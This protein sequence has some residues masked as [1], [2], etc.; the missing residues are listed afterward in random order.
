MNLPNVLSFF[1]LCLVPVFVLVYFS[2]AAHAGVYA[3]IVYGIA[4]LSD[5]LD[6]KIA[7]KYHMTSTLGKILDPLGDKLMTFA[8]LIC[9]TIDRVVPLWAILIFVAKESL[10]GI[11]GLILFKRLSD[12]PPSNYFG[13]CP[14]I[15]FFAVCV[16]LIL[17]KRNIS[18]LGA[19]IM[20]SVAI[21][22]TLVAFV[23]Y[24][25]KFARMISGGKTK[26]E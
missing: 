20:I 25:L 6:G 16:I 21:A 13:K 19:T 2:G 5:V 4:A 23:S 22:V 1:R 10:M 26:Q 14:T 8:V 18:H 9:I 24:V 7:R 12:M 11:G 3:V 17:F 15:V